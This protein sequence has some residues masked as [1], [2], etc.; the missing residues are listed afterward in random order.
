MTNWHFVSQQLRV[1]HTSLALVLRAAAVCVA[2][3]LVGCAGW[4]PPANTSEQPLRARAVSA[5]ARE[6]R[7]S[8]AVLSA[9]DGRRMFGADVEATGIQPVWIEVENNSQ[10]TLWL[11]RTGV[12]PDYFSPLEVAWSFHTTFAAATNAKLDEHFDAQGFANPIPAGVTRSGVVF[13]NPQPKGKVLNIDLLGDEVLIPFTLV[14]PVS[15]DSAIVTLERL[16]RRLPISEVRDY[17]DE[18][19]FR[20]LLEQLPCCGTNESGTAQGDPINVVLVGKLG[21][22]AT[23]AGRRGFRVN[24]LEFDRQ[25]RVLARPPDVVVR[26]YAQGGAAS[27]WVRAW[28]AP[29]RF[30]GKS[31]FLAQVGRPRGGRFRAPESNSLVLHPDVDEARNLLIQ[32]MVYSSGLAK[33]GF[34]GGVGPASPSAP[35][36]ALGSSTYHTDGLRAVLFFEARPLE[37]GELEILDWVPY[38]ERREQ[39]AAGQTDVDSH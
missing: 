37:L 26:K 34:V 9:E 19:A 15:D 30:K 27:T 24:P 7:V 35:R 25:Q 14:L 16:Q 29:I 3:A 31:V 22:I 33:L 10:Q 36:A 1:P 6:V 20:E 38:L 23:P 39:R 18:T 12:D 28:L 32:D 17:Q 2:L 8:A 5:S 4:Q 21:D 11:L 13:T